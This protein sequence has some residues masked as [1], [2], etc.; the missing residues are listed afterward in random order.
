MFAYVSVT[1]LD[2]VTPADYGLDEDCT[3]EEFE[4]A[5]EARVRLREDDIENSSGMNMNDIEID[6]MEGDWGK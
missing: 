1:L 3:E 5:I 4:A 6:V 2:I